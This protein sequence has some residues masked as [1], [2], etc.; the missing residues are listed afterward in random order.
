MATD[1]VLTPLMRQYFEIKNQFPDA[2]VLFQVGDFYELFFGDAQNASAFL[3]IVLTQR[4][5]MNSEPIPLC[6]VPRHTVEHYI[7]KLIKGGFRIVLCDQLE[8][9]QPGKLVDRGVTQVFTP[10]TLVDSKLLESKSSHYLA[11]VVIVEGKLALALYEMLAATIYLTE[12]DYDEKKLDA[13]LAAFSPQEVLVESTSS[14]KQLEQFCRQRSLITTPVVDSFLRSDSEGWLASCQRL[15]SKDSLTHGAAQVLDL[16]GSYIKKNAAHSFE[17]AKNLLIYQ[18][19]DFLQLDAA[20]QKNLELIHN[21]HD[22]SS[23]HTVLQVLDEAVTG[24]G[25]RL[26]KKYL[27]RPLVDRALIEKRLDRIDFFVKQSF[28][29]NDVRTILKKIGDLERVVGRLTLHRAPFN[30]Y[31]SLKETIAEIPALKKY[32]SLDIPELTK[33]YS[34]LAHAINSDD[35]TQWKIAAGYH[36]ELDRLR[37]LSTQGM[38][39]I[40]ELERKEQQKSGINTLKIRYSQAAGYAIEVS[41]SQAESVPVYYIKL[42]SLTNRD[43]FTTQE[44]KDLEYDMS[45]AESKSTELENQLFS[46]VMREVEYFVPLLRAIAQDLAELDLATGL[47]HTAI[48]NHWVRPE[49]T[50]AA[51][52]VIQNG[53]HPIV[54]ARMR[55]NIFVPNDTQLT[56]DQRTWIITGPNMGGKSTYLRQNA[57]IAI[58]AQ[59]G[60]FVPAT[61]A[62]LPLLDRIFTRIGAGDHLAEGKSTFLVEMEETALICNKAT[63]RS[64]VILD[65]VGRGTSTYDG[66]ALA[67]AIVEYLHETIKPFCLFAT[68]YHELTQLA[69]TTPGIACYHAASK[70]V[71]ESVILLHKILPGVAEGSFGIQVAL[72]AQV[73]GRVISRARI[74]L[75]EYAQMQQTQLPQASMAYQ[76]AVGQNV[77]LDSAERKKLELLEDIDLDALSPRQAYDMLCRLKEL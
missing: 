21:S 8:A 50:D 64:F 31:K 73:P 22:G 43:R 29:R 65:E 63:E 28:D 70:P 35:H 61:R 33:L 55:P 59:M 41:K 6:G 71:K 44:L 45:R 66:L 54:E 18:A 4:G 14:G 15:A 72:A 47:A 77:E 34:L 10:G 51:E 68:H 76:P 2:L 58:L 39:A 56:A 5:T 46:G 53:R 60:S 25:S 62:I 69:H 1:A 17:T 57:L 16:L 24:M 23:N 49:F 48:L 67:Q 38:Q 40:F 12:F 26:L 3:G 7:V 52:M 11:A 13:E 74:L 27:V 37:G 30:D 32:L 42:Q 20:T 75:S 36:T 19:Q 9:P